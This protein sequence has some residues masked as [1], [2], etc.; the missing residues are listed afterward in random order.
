[1]SSIW[2]FV[3][4]SHW[5]SLF[6]FNFF[7][8]FIGPKLFQ[9]YDLNGRPYNEEQI[10]NLYLEILEEF[11]RD[12]PDFIGG[13]IIYAPIKNVLNDTA[14]NYFKVIP[15]LH[16]SFPNFFAGFD[17][18]GQEDA[19]PPLISFAKNLLQ[20]PKKINF[21]IHA[22]E[23]NWFGSTDENLVCIKFVELFL[24]QNH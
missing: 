9:I 18:V 16:A 14:Q 2:N 5:Y 4:V 1:M 24:P 6:T 20:V 17:L 22:G 19:S 23:T 13:K 8:D 7:H 21:F 3:A 11:K 15:R 12:N 10:L